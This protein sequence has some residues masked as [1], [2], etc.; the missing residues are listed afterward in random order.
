MSTS[1]GDSPLRAGGCDCG[2][3]C[4][5]VSGPMRAVV[6]CHCGQCRRTHGHFASYS[7]AA[8]ADLHFTEQRGLRWYRSSEFARRGFC[9][10]CG[11]SL[12]WARDDADDISIAAGTLHGSTGLRSIAHIFMDDAGDYYEL[13]DDLPRYPGAMP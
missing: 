2:G 6:N 12:F 3:V 8:G 9:G 10:E 11:A 1:Q 7:S 13:Q 5:E 4:Y